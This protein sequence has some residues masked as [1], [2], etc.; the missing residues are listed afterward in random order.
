MHTE[1]IKRR[2]LKF[3]GQGQRSRQGQTIKMTYFSTK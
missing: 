3:S 1:S 2:L